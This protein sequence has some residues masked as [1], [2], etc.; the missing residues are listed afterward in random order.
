MFNL[1]EDLKQDYYILKFV[2]EGD[3]AECQEAGAAGDEGVGV[4][5]EAQSIDFQQNDIEH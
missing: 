3:D 1:Q 4:D 5:V 2:G